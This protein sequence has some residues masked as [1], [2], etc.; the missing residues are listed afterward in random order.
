MLTS[1]ILSLIIS[2]G[3]DQPIP[4]ATLS[5]TADGDTIHLVAEGATPSTF[6]TFI[7]STP[8]TEPVPFYNGALCG[9]WNPIRHTPIQMTDSLGGATWTG[10][11]EGTQPT[12][13]V[14]LMYRT[15]Q[16]GFGGDLSSGIIVQRVP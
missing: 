5:A 16:F 7:Y 2:P 9:S 11:L 8:L 4:G 12:L 10:I 6:C 3:C 14:Q 13:S 1:L 15:P